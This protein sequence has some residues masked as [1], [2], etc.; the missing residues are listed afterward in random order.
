M[1]ESAEKN[2][3]NTNVMIQNVQDNIYSSISQLAGEIVSTV[4][5]SIIAQITGDLEVELSNIN[6]A[7]TQTKDSWTFQFNQFWQE[8]LTTNDQIDARFFDISKYI[9]FENGN[10][11]LGEVGNELQLK[12]QNNR[13]SF[14]QSGVEVAYI[15]NKKLYITDGEFLTSLTLGNFGFL[16][17][18]NGNLSFKRVK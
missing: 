14:I 8:F 4:G 16:P 11:I 15:N 12:L 1:V 5:E 17:R 10:I 18:A 9:R 13:I 6:T 2:I 3:I 7:L